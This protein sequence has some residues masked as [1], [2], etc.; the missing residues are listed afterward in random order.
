MYHRG[1]YHRVHFFFYSRTRGPVLRH[2]AG[3]KAGGRGKELVAFL[4]RLLLLFRVLCSISN[5]ASTRHVRK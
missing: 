1:R 3:T 5:T 2:S 4:G